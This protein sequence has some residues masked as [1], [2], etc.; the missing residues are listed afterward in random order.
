MEIFN[1]FENKIYDHNFVIFGIDAILQ[2]YSKIE[3]KILSNV[4]TFI[5]ENQSTVCQITYPEIFKTKKNLYE[6]PYVPG[7]ETL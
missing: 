4:S 1:I 6:I 3:K 2:R 5:F 7:F